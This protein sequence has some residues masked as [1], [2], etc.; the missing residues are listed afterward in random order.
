MTADAELVLAS[1]AAGVRTLTLH[2]PERRN[3]W[4][5]AMEERYFGLLDEADADPSFGSS[6]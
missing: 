2:N 6:W 3:A 4:S 1:T 5:V